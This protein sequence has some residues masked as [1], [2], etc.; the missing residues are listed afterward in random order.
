MITSDDINH[1]FLKEIFIGADSERALA[2]IN[3]KRCDSKWT[4]DYEHSLIAAFML[5]VH[6][7]DLFICQNLINWDPSLRYIACLA[8]LGQKGYDYKQKISK[9]YLKGQLGQGMGN[10]EK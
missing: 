10:D 4:R 3:E 8:M 7:E 1:E 9:R 5:A 2:L 6:K